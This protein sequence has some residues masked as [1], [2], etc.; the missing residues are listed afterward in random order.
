MNKIDI[1]RLKEPQVYHSKSG[2]YFLDLE[3][4]KVKKLISTLLLL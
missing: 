2:L 4:T 3:A 1:F